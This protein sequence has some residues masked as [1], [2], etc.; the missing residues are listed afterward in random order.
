METKQ[1]FCVTCSATNEQ[2]HEDAWAETM[3]D[4]AIL[5]RAKEFGYADTFDKIIRDWR[6]HALP[7]CNPFALT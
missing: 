1:D 3:A 6:T 5:I 7:E 2:E 4:Y